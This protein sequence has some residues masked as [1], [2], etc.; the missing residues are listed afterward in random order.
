MQQFEESTKNK[1]T[2]IDFIEEKTRQLE[3]ELAELQAQ[4]VEREAQEKGCFSCNIL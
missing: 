1:Q 3:L 2:E 4:Q